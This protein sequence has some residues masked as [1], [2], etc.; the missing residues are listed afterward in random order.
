MCPPKALF[1]RL[2]PS[3]W[4]QILTYRPCAL[5]SSSSDSNPPF[6]PL[7]PPRPPLHPS[8]RGQMRVE[9][10]VAT[11]RARHDQ[12]LERLKRELMDA[13]VGPM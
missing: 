9:K 2:Y 7:I 4:M 10:E 12:Q 3:P 6:F 1:R 13:Q 5:S 11:V 8:V